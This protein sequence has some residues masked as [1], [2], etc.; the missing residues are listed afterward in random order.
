[1]SQLLHEIVRGVNEEIGDKLPKLSSE[2]TRKEMRRTLLALEKMTKHIRK[3]LLRESK[4]LAASRKQARLLKKNKKN[5]S[6]DILNS[7]NYNDE[8]KEDV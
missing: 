2:K 1:M 8:T 5:N 7:E 3:E 6:R 4:E